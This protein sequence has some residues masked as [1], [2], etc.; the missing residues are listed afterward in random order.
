VS[1]INDALKKTQ[2]LRKSIKNKKVNSVVE[3][4]EKNKMNKEAI[5]TSRRTNMSRAQFNFMWKMTSFLT[6][7]ALLIL[8]MITNQDRLVRLSHQYLKTADNAKPAVNKMTVVFDGVFISDSNKIAL[9]NKKQMQVGDLLNGMPI[10]KID[11]N[12]IALQS[13]E[14]VLEL[15]AGA[16]YLL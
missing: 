15:K 13:P 14:G 2:Q 3:A 6:V 10:V 5:R 7:T 11:Q 1:I 12:H 9:I 16:T 8:I 4:E